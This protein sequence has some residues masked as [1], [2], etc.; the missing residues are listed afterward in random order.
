MSTSNEI[1]ATIQCPF[2]GIYYNA[3]DR[4]SH[5]CSRG[6]SKGFQT[7]ERYGRASSLG[8]I[9]DEMHKRFHGRI[10]EQFDNA[11]DAM[12]RVANELT[13]EID[14]EDEE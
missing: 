11:I 6:Y 13:A 1:Q 10:G 9:V 3:E 14:Q 2:C 4:E 7:G 8:Q 12:E 5:P